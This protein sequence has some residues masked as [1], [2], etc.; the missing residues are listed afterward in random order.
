MKIRT[1]ITPNEEIEVPQWEADFLESQGLVHHSR[2]KTDEGALRSE[3]RQQIEAKAA[4]VGDPRNAG[5]D[6]PDDVEDVD[7][8]NGE[9]ADTQQNEE[10]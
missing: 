4:A 3:I 9:P 5:D 7:E 8:N 6:E 1:T 2:A 10:S